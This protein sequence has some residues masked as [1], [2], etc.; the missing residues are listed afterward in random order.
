M[1]L[2]G[3]YSRGQLKERGWTDTLIKR[4]MPTHDCEKGQGTWNSRTKATGGQ[5]FYLIARL[6][7]VEASPE[8]KA[9]QKKQN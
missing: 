6:E 8:F 2:A 1:E 4:F 3:Y 5:Y 7:A 9:K